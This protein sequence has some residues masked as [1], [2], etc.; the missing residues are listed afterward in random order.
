LL[1]LSFDYGNPKIKCAQVPDALS[2]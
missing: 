1:A 2:V